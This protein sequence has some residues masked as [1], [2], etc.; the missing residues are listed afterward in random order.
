VI[1]PNDPG[2]PRDERLSN[3][4]K[5]RAIALRCDDWLASFFISI[6]AEELALTPNLGASPKSV[7]IIIDD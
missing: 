7:V 1:A 5:S 6:N 3:T 2:Q 4:E